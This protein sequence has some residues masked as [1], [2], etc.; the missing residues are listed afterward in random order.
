MPKCGDSIYATSFKN[1]ILLSGITAILGVTFGSVVGY[2]ICQLKSKR[3]QE[4]V[5]ALCAT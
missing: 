2:F 4:L 3:A 1:S 5:T